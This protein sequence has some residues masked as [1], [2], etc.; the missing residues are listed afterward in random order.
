MPQLGYLECLIVQA[1]TAPA[2]GPKLPVHL[3]ESGK[4]EEGRTLF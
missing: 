2:L 1:H 4:L 3:Q